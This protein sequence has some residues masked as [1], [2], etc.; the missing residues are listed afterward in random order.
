MS[1]AQ[2]RVILV[3]DDLDEAEVLSASLSARGFQVTLAEDA[4]EAI[5]A[6]RG[7]L[8]ELLILDYDLEDRAALPVF[9]AAR[10]LPTPL[11]TVVL[12]PPVVDPIDAVEF[13][14]ADDELTKPIS[15][16]DLTS[17]LERLT[18]RVRSKPSARA[19]SAL[20][21]SPAAM[22]DVK[23]TFDRVHTLPRGSAPR[24]SVPTSGRYDS[25]GGSAS[26]PVEPRAPSGANPVVTRADESAATVAGGRER[27]APRRAVL[28]TVFKIQDDTSSTPFRSILY[29]LFANRM[30]GVIRLGDPGDVRVLYFVEGWPVFARSERFS[31]TLGAVL[32]QSDMLS[33]GLVGEAMD[34]HAEG[35][36]LGRMLLER[37][38]LL[39]DQL[40][41]ALARQ[42]YETFM[43]CFESPNTPYTFEFSTDWLSEVNTFPQNPLRLI[44][45]GVRRFV[46]A[47][48][49]ADGLT[50][51]LEDYVV[52]T[53]KFPDFVAHFPATPQEQAWIDLIDGTRTLR[54]LTLQA[55]GHVMELL[56]LIRALQ[57]AD[58]I[59]FLDHP[60]Q[61]AER[62]AER[63]FRRSFT[64]DWDASDLRGAMYGEAGPSD[65]GPRQPAPAP[66]QP[67][68]AR[69][70]PRPAPSQPPQRAQRPA[71]SA[72]PQPAAERPAPYPRPEPSGVRPAPA[73]AA[74]RPAQQLAPQP[75]PQ[76]RAQAAPQPAPRPA[77]APAP[78]AGPVV[79][80][81]GDA[82]ERMIMDYYLRL[83]HD[84]YWDLLGV[85]RNARPEVVK[86]AFRDIRDAFTPQRLA[87]LSPRMR[88]YAEQVQHALQRAYNTLSDPVLA[89]RYADRLQR[90]GGG[91][92]A[93][94]ADSGM[95]SGPGGSSAPAPAE[96]PL[97]KRNTVERLR[98]LA[99]RGRA[100][101]ED[102]ERRR[103]GGRPAPL[104]PA[105]TATEAGLPPVE[106]AR[107]CMKQG[108]WAG[109]LQ[110]LREAGGGH[111]DPEILCLEAWC[112]Y[113][114]PNAD[115]KQQADLARKR[116]L[117]AITLNADNP[118]A[119]YLLGRIHE[120]EGSVDKAMTCFRDTLRLYPGHQG[121]TKRLAA[122]RARMG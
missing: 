92:T 108:L 41:A 121:A 106:R 107:R 2:A 17:A 21:A 98:N 43:G 26:R 85:G 61:T 33:A 72:P 40:D 28:N 112:I 9:K 51:V 109:A 99:A 10:G 89:L 103:T 52:Q 96:R 37:G 81:G 13:A 65:S 25:V 20:A 32:V 70:A 95:G 4:D 12:M 64:S 67:G 102:A 60:R 101:A 6:I 3:M 7:L 84:N 55:R 122:L 34:R 36:A 74:P 8:P 62:S 116:L 5:E 75:Q 1:R 114:L 38:L 46:E 31:E 45:D 30:T 53:E 115:R 71:P 42:V 58:M 105:P 113:N 90:G 83:P 86:R 119:H 118:E 68:P 44:A 11:P 27:T 104:P 57:D 69:P 93:G 16:D 48:E 54:E 73:P 100:L 82:L 76:P 35:A 78:A 94:A 111:R 97:P 66:A 120:N 77:L 117:L 22:A 29:K 80:L 24:R 14:E 91:G 110:I 56:M 47:N 18:I 59:D 15:A 63:P 19:G 39:P 49:L 79:Q 87:T 23:P 50:G 88:R